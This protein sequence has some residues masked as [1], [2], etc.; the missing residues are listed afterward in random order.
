MIL[1]AL[2]MSVMGLKKVWMGVGGWGELYAFFLGFLEFVELC[3]A[4]YSLPASLRM[5]GSIS[6]NEGLVSGAS[7]QHF[8]TSSVIDGPISLS[9]GSWGRYGVLSPLRTRVMTTEFN[10]VSITDLKKQAN[11]DLL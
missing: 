9:S 11:I 7:C 8:S 10:V 4:P 6:S 1:G 5:S 2:S 3:K